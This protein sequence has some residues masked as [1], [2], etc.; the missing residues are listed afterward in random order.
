[1][2]KKFPVQEINMARIE[3][4]SLDSETKS[5]YTVNGDISYLENPIANENVRPTVQTG[6]EVTVNGC[7]ISMRFRNDVVPDLEHDIALML[8]DIFRKR[9][10]KE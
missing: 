7:R 6:P 8:L 5:V 2:Q 9:H 1:M 10:D 3:G 4:S